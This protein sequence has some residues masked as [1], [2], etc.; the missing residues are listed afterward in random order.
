MPLHT[1]CIQLFFSNILL[2]L[3]ELLSAQKNWS[4]IFFT[5]EVSSYRYFQSL[6]DFIV[7]NIF[8]N[9]TL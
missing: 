9:V 5:N 4:N 7:S 8:C 2:A 3:N 6:S 1:I